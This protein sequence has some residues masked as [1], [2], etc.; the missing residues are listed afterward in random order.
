MM[1]PRCAFYAFSGT[2]GHGHAHIAVAW[3]RIRMVKV[4][5]KKLTRID[6]KKSESSEENSLFCFPN[7]IYY[8]NLLGSKC[9]MEKTRLGGKAIGSNRSCLNCK[10]QSCNRHPN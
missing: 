4:S 1:C 6:Y 8:V 9:I 2:G 10:I 5:V 7:I 3:E